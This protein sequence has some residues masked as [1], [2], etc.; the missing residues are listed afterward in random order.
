MTK[1]TDRF[2]KQ[3]Q[4]PRKTKN[5]LRYR[6]EDPDKFVQKSFRNVPISH[7]N[8]KG[9]IKGER[10]IVGKMKKTGKWKIQSI[11]KKRKK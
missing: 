1:K 2:K 3:G 6:Q 10:A 9:K 4:Y 11:L 7:T 8:Y 5:W